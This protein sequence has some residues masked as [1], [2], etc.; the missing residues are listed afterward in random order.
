MKTHSLES[1]KDKYIGK[2]G[3]PARQAYE[4]E[5]RMDVMG[6]AIK[7]LRLAK[8]LTQEQ[9]GVLVGVQKAQIS[10][11]ESSAKNATLATVVK[12]FQA[13][14]TDIYFTVRNGGEV[15]KLE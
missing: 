11:L 6:Q 4:L 2:D 8:G 3:T 7:E 5:L 9:L 14:A 12:V 10:K 15:L 1:L 13:M